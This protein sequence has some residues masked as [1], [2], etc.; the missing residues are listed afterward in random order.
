MRS[1]VI[2][3]L[4]QKEL[5]DALRDRRTLLT[6][7]ITPILFPVL[8]FGFSTLTVGH[9][10]ET[11]ART[12]TLA[13]DGEENGMPLM[14]NLS[15][16]DTFELVPLPDDINGSL[17]TGAVQVVVIIPEGFNQSI[18]NRTPTEIVV[19]YDAS[20]AQ[21]LNAAT[22]FRTFL[23]DYEDTVVDVRLEDENLTRELIEPFSIGFDNRAS[24]EKEEGLLLSLILPLA[25]VSWVVFGGM[26][27]AIDI[28]AGEKERRTLES[29]LV[30]PATRMEL[31][32]GKFLATF[33]ITM[34]NM[35]IM[36][37][38]IILPV[39]AAPDMIGEGTRLNLDAVGF[40]V[41]IGVLLLLAVM[42]NALQLAVCIFAKS[43]REAQYY[44]S[45]FTIFTIIP[46]MFFPIVTVVGEE[47]PAG[48]YWAPIMNVIFL[49]Q[50]QLLGTQNWYH[51][52]IVV[53]STALYSV[54][55]LILASE[56]FK[57][58]GVLFRD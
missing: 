31:V 33:S 1:K 52:G 4:L 39:A 43:V 18:N 22:D 51:V 36:I 2:W 30:S 13:V 7:L 37:V 20:R 32:M 58:E 48:V 38:S 55:C 54:I 42:S 12:A 21:S 34:L 57:R 15:A 5:L 8:I 19:L 35:V 17:R 23:Q 49:F 14:E 27:I 29:I 41:L 53:F 26:N 46:V 50:E 10:E 45:P 9:I 44:V 6:M 28:T 47:L 40:G 24:E 11:I 25:V 3:Y 16:N 56:M